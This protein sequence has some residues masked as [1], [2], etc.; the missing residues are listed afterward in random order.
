MKLYYTPG[1]CAMAPHIVFE[2]IGTPYELALADRSDPAFK[3]IN[4]MGAV[5]ALVTEDLGTLTQCGAI[6][7]YQTRLAGAAYG[8][9]PG[10]A[11]EAYEFD[12]WEC[13]FTGDVHPAFFPFFMPFRFTKDVS[14]EALAQVRAAA[15]DLVSRAFAVLDAHLEG[16]R[17]IIGDR[18]TFIDAY[19]TP[20]IRWAKTGLPDTYAKFPNIQRH[21]QMMAADPGVQRAMAQQG[22]EA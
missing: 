15:P 10:D 19:A 8:P 9:K 18:L 2:W 21:Y 14:E 22:I 11:R 12:H 4:P 16:R 7:R 5:P 17:T 20:M 6:M 3:V 13:F 1:A